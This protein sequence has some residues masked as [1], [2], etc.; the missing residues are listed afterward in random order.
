VLPAHDR[1]F[2]TVLSGIVTIAGRTVHAG[3]TAWSDPVA[4]AGSSTIAVHSDDRDTP[5]VVLAFSGKPIRQPVAMGGPFVM[6]SDAE[7]RQAF[8]DFHA[9]KFGAIPRQARLY[10]R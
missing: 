6:N 9:G 1:A 3:Q 5:S 10:Y 7:I 8:R 4:A 2:F